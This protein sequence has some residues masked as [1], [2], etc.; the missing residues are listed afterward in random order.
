MNRRK[1]ALDIIKFEHAKYGE[2][3]ARAHRAS[4][5]INASA[6]EYHNAAKAGME[7]YRDAVDKNDALDELVKRAARHT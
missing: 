6:D 7:I 5:K 2:S 3:T 1:H 4:E